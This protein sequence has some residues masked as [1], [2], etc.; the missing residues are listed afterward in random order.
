MAMVGIYN[1]MT[2]NSYKDTT[3]KIGRLSKIVVNDL[4]YK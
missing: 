1:L 4:D 3:F 2:Y